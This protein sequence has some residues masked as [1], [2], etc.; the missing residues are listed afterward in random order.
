MMFRAIEKAKAYMDCTRY[1][2]AILILGLPLMGALFSLP[3]MNWAVGK[4]IIFFLAASFIAACHFNSLNEYFDRFHD[5]LDKRR[6]NQPHLSGKVAPS[7]LLALS[8]VLLFASLFLYAFLSLR[9]LAVFFIVFLLHMG[10]SHPRIFLKG[11]PVLSAL[12]FL[13]GGA[14]IFLIGYTLFHEIDL[15]GALLALYFGMIYIAAC[16]NH[17]IQDYD[18]DLKAGVR[19]NAVA[20]GKKKVFLASFILFSISPLYLGLLGYF[21][22]V[23]RSLSLIVILGYLVYLHLF[24]R[25]L[26]EGVRYE[27]IHKFRSGYRKLYGIMGIC[28][29]ILVLLNLKG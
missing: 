25:V 14:L 4:K 13:V 1:R 16:L 8:I 6:L 28:F 26:R 5:I 3:T 19:T 18:T 12:D 29:A 11:K 23:P 2:E 22:V 17:E 20:F 10:Y 27:N 9:T 7:E 24:L 21:H 15:K